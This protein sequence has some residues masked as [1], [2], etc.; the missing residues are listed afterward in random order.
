MAGNGREHREHAPDLRFPCR[1][2]FPAPGNTGNKLP[3]RERAD[4]SRSVRVPNRTLADTAVHSRAVSRLPAQPLSSLSVSSLLFPAG[5]PG[6]GTGFGRRPSTSR[7][8]LEA[9]LGRPVR[10]VE[11]GP[12]GGPRLPRGS[13]TARRRTPNRRTAGQ[14]H[15]P[16]PESSTSPEGTPL[17]PRGS[18]PPGERPSR[19]PSTPARPSRA[20][21][22]RQ[23]AREPPR[24]SRRSSRTST[25]PA[26]APARPGG[27]RA[28]EASGSPACHPSPSLTS[29]VG[30]AGKG[31]SARGCRSI[32][33][34]TCRGE[35]WR[36]GSVQVM[37]QPLVQAL[38][39][40]LVR[41][42]HALTMG[43]PGEAGEPLER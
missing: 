25:S 36:D 18:Y 9:S 38:V 17:R 6:Q 31:K 21:P 28:P 24:T 20:S 23:A 27:H 1:S 33:G 32:W 34:L 37:V 11:Q 3:G 42:H 2:L 4:W 30:P 40:P 5:P 14:G 15:V 7:E 16:C 35:W 10:P 12:G 26:P 29:S 43:P 13:L 39:Q 8:A 41:T 19:G 22:A